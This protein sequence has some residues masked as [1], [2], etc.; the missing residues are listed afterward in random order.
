MSWGRLKKKK[1]K[2][3]SPMMAPISDH[4]YLHRY[5]AVLYKNKR[6]PE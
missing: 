6:L 3:I 5:L 4:R 2:K 1:K